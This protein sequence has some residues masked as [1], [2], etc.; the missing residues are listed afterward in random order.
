VSSL[1]EPERWKKAGVRLPRGVLLEGPPGSGKTLLARA[2]AGEAGV[3]VFELSASEFV[4]MF[5]GVGAARVRDTFDMAAKAAPAVLFIDE[6]DAI[7]RRRGSGVGGSHDEREQTLNQL[8]VCL[9]GFSPLKRLVVVAATNRADILDQALLRPGRFDLRVTLPPMSAEDRLEVLRIHS[10]T[11][12]LAP[13][14]DLT[15]LAARL[16]GRSA[17]S[18]ESMVNEAAMKAVRRGDGPVTMADFEACFTAQAQLEQRY[19][20]VDAIL[21]ESASQLARPQGHAP[22]EIELDDGSRHVGAVLWADAAYVKLQGDTGTVILSKARIKLVRV[23]EGAAPID[24][25][26]LRSDAF[27]QLRTDVG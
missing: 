16:E 3:A 22:V 17:A 13:E 23:G 26:A 8:L 10:R 25:G 9:D 12:A 1:K 20:A 2:I 18:I 14:V 24:E 6:I 5:V 11:K 21:S 19:D 15:A 27:A 7:G 4:E